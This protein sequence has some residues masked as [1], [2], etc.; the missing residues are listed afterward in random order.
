MKRQKE[1]SQVR[2]QRLY[3]KSHL[4]LVHIHL[5]HSG[6][7]SLSTKYILYAIGLALGSTCFGLIRFLL[8]PVHSLKQFFCFCFLLCLRLCGLLL[9]CT[10]SAMLYGC[11]MHDAYNPQTLTWYIS[12]A[13]WLARSHQY[14]VF[15]CHNLPKY[16]VFICQ[17]FK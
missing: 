8:R 12:V 5:G 17:N 6:T 15:D 11:C 4:F 1:K 14:H 3:F 16:W 9:L 2:L 13:A 10:K 7:L